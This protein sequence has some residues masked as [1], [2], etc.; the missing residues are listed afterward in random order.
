MQS[1][2]ETPE[3]DGMSV[4]P[5]PKRYRPPFVTE[6]DEA[7]WD[8]CLVCSILMATA[9]WTLGETVMG[10]DWR[11]LNAR[12]L[13]RL[14]ELLRN[15][16]PADKQVGALTF[17]DAREF[18][19]AEWPYLPPVEFWDVTERTWPQVVAMLGDG[20]VGVA[21]GNPQDVTDPKS[22][23]RR[24]TTNDR[25]AHVIYLDRTSDKGI[26]V[27]DPLGSGAYDGEFVPTAE[28]RQFVGKEGDVVH[29]AMFER[30][31]QS[32][33][34]IARRTAADKLRDVRADLAS[35]RRDATDLAAALR[36]AQK[37]IKELEALPPADCTADV[38]AARAE[39][40]SQAIGAI[41][42]LP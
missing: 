31:S 2:P 24:W 6:T 3:G 8:D 23:L 39:A 11:P 17:A 5:D 40:L 9:A 30:G 28:V 13:K 38:A 19:D 15:H 32:S 37:R 10:N 12:E 14:R 34:A 26:Y 22:K 25:F 33:L 36:A 18:V 16:L 20:W 7:R 29:V 35:C 4:L 27:M 1:Q 42:A 41:E 21:A